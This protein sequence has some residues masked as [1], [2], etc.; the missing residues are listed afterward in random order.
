MNLTV[1]QIVEF[2]VAP[3]NALTLIKRINELTP[4]LTLDKLWQVISK[5]ILTPDHPF[6]LHLFLFN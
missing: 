6:E 1:N 4:S 3:S 5:E 2:G